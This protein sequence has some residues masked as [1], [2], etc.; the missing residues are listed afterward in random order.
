MNADLATPVVIDTNRVLDLWLFDE[1][2]V[3][4]LR[5][6]LEAGAVRW[7]ATAAMR[8]EL[9]R[10]LGYPAIVAQS[11]RRACPPQTVLAAFDRWANPVAAAAPAAVRCHDADDQIFIDLAVAWRAP[12]ISRDRL[13]L[14]LARRLLPWGVVV[15]PLWPEALG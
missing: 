12:L 8:A 1:A 5:R 4:P 3:A 13:V 10:V 2:E 15:A 7:L 9:A 14:Q 11:E 6:A